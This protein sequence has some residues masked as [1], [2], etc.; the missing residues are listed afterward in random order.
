MT[1]VAVDAGLTVVLAQQAVQVVDTDDGP[2]EALATV[3]RA[4]RP[5]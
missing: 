3:V 2:R 1:E 5:L 4:D